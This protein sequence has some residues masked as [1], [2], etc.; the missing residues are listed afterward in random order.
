EACKQLGLKPWECLAVEDA[1]NGIKSAAAAGC[2]VVFV[3]DQTDNEP[4]VEPLCVGKVKT[5]DE[6]TN[7]FV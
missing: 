5:A 6:I 1:P 3:P 2:R 7:L 4:E